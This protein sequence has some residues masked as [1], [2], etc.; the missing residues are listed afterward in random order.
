[1]NQ[2]K[3]AMTPQM[4]YKYDTTKWGEKLFLTQL[5]NALVSE[6]VINDALVIHQTKKRI[7]LDFLN[8]YEVKITSIKSNGIYY[9]IDYMI[10]PL[11]PAIKLENNVFTI[12]L[13]P[14]EAQ[15]AFKIIT[16]FKELGYLTVKDF[17]FD[18]FSEVNRNNPIIRSDSS[19]KLKSIFKSAEA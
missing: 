2:R 3:N 5:R 8:S 12:C 1:M 14:V 19:V 4:K 16:N 11:D 9:I 6:E 7:N 13:N 10:S 15:K 18:M 17:N